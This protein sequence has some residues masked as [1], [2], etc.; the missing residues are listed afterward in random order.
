MTFDR[1]IA[2][3]GILLAASLLLAPTAP[4]AQPGDAPSCAGQLTRQ[5]RRFNEKCLS[6]LVAYVASQ[7]RMGARIESEGEKYYVLLVKDAKGFRAEAVSKFNFA[8]MRDETATALKRLGWAP[9]ENE[10]DN[11]KKPV[12]EGAEAGAVA[13]DAMEA[14]QAYGLKPGEAISLT[15]GP[16][17]SS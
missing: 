13:K 7:P 17:L 1:R 4:G 2:R 14:L 12:A 16:D 5:L 8:F 9:P 6:D 11:W 3:A 10:N 15:V